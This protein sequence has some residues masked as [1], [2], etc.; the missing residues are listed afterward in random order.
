[1]STSDHNLFL[2]P[3]ASRESQPEPE[4]PQ[5]RELP[6]GGP[7]PS[8][9]HEE[10]FTSPPLPDGAEDMSELDMPGLDMPRRD[11]PG[12]RSGATALG[13]ASGRPEA[14]SPRR[15]RRRGTDSAQPTRQRR[16]RRG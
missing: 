5:D 6:P 7:T 12:R 15:T 2:S 4:V 1:M 16:A 11:V 13:G 10:I 9:T 14:A 3:G 8:W